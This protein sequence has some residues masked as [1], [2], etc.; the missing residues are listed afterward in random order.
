M[1]GQSSQ[2]NQVTSY[3]VIAERAIEVRALLAG[4]QRT[5]N[6]ESRLKMAR[7]ILS[8]LV[9]S[10][11]PDCLISYRLCD[12]FFKNLHQFDGETLSSFMVPAIFGFWC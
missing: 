10:K 9:A 7:R 6:Q 2:S 8:F 3:K 5:K 1:D 12:S 4:E 11:T